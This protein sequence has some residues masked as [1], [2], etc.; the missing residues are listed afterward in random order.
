MFDATRTGCHRHRLIDCR[1][2]TE[3][4]ALFCVAHLTTPTAAGARP[5]VHFP[6]RRVF[7]WL[8]PVGGSAI[9]TNDSDPS[10]AR[11]GLYF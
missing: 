5:V 4:P 2:A 3:E 6:I 1:R 7:T 8:V 9:P 10:P 11:L